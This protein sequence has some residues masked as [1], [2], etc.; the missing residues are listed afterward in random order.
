MTETGIKETKEA[1]VALIKIAGLIVPHLKDGF[2]A[3]K[4]LPAIFGEWMSDAEFQAELKAGVDGIHLVPE[5]IK[6]ITVAE[7]LALAGAL[8]PE[9]IELIEKLS[10]KA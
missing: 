7:G 9:V 1:G 2:Q 6:G 4:D 5:E 8:Y 10:K 3:G